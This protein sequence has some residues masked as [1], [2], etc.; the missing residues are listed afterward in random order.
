LRIALEQQF[1][2]SYAAPDEAAA[3]NVGV[4]E[5]LMPELERLGDDL[6][7]AKAW[8]L[9]SE[10]ELLACR[11]QARTD[12]LE[13][14]LTHARRSPDAREEPT[15]IAAQLAFALYY[16]PTPVPNAI[17]RCESL[18]DDAAGDRALCAALTTSLAGLRAMNG[19][20]GE[21]RRLYAN[22]VAVHDE[23]GM[24]FRR[25]ACA[26][27]GAN[28]EALAGDLAAAERELR[29]ACDALAAAG[30]RGVRSTLEGVL[31]QL[32][33]ASGH[34]DEAERHARESAAA[35]SEI[36]TA[37]QVLWRAVLAQVLARRGETAEGRVLAVEA[38][39]LART[40][41]FP[42]LRAAALLGLAVV[43]ACID[44]DAALP[45]VAAAR[46]VYAAKGNVVAASALAERALVRPF[47]SG[48]VPL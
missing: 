17:S 19:E 27:I 3:D 36:D 32:L 6:G 13:R 29:M 16:G 8:W 33:A 42:E 31:A 35:A 37:P 48:P 12:A 30:E 9:K 2:R 45:L 47:T 1:L 5:E 43:T 39:Q 18:L 21:A 38:D 11:W 14:A 4:A 23:L 44:A 15:A 7:L 26:A 25:L 34:D 20:F 24:R 41:D 28:I 46:E 10:G 22:A 40:T